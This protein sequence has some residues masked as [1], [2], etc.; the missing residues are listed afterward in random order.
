MSKKRSKSNSSK[1]RK[2]K[3][4]SS[5]KKVNKKREKGNSGKDKKKKSQKEKKEEEEES[6][7]ESS[8]LKRWVIAVVMF[9]LALIVAFAFFDKAG[10][11][12]EIIL[13]AFEFLIGQAGFSIPF[14]LVLG[15]ILLVRPCKKRVYA[16]IFGGLLLFIVAISGIFETN[17]G[18]KAGG[19]IGYIFSWPF[20]KYFTVLVSNIVFSACM[21]IAVLILWE[22][23]PQKGKIK[24]PPIDF[25]K[26]KE[27]INRGKEEEQE[28]ADI[29]ESSQPEVETPELGVKENQESLEGKKKDRKEKKAKEKESKKELGKQLGLEEEKSSRSSASRQDYNPPPLNLLGLPKGR[30]SGG[31][32]QKDAEIIKETLANFGISVEMGE[33]SVG[34]TV[35]RYTLKPDK[36]I[37]LS[38]IT[39]LN[40]DLALALA[41]HPI[42]IEAPIPGRA[43]VGVEV[44][45][46][47]KTEVRLRELLASSEFQKASTPLTFSLGKDVSG[48][49]VLTDLG[50]MPHLLVAG[51]TG[52]GKT[53]FLQGLITSFL[54]RN[55]PQKLRLMLIDPKRVEFSIYKSIPHV[56]GPVI[57][58][59]SKAVNVLNWLVEE[60]ERRFDLMSEVRA[61]D[62]SAFNATISKHQK[63]KEKY[64]IMPRI[65]L[66]IDE[67]ADLMAAK[68]K[69][70]ES[71]IVR[72]SQLSRAVGIHLVVATQRP[73]VDV[74]TGLIKANLIARVA[75]QVAGQA[76][77]RTVLDMGGAENLLGNGDMLFLPSDSAKPKRVQGT[78]VAQENVK[79]VVEYVEQ[80][81]EFEDSGEIEKRLS[82]GLEESEEGEKNENLEE[83]N[84]PLYNKAKEMVVEY[85]KASASFIQ[86]RLGVGYAR[87][88]RIMDM[89]EQEGVVSP[90]EGS[91]PRQILIDKLDSEE[92]EE[93][94]SGSSEES[95]EESEDEDKGEDSDWE[96]T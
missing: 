50:K 95:Q 39:A 96:K 47:G 26:I 10:K 38:R 16:Y 22:V 83:F 77:S 82:E 29:E 62:I 23:V 63:L 32:T 67:L 45:N 69:E 71:S 55:S 27:K 18:E 57:H 58:Q 64:G 85:R 49:L 42:R 30:P 40:N 37:K 31:N 59:P 81:N 25:S 52:S 35:T 74:I 80:H 3:K 73:S 7:I 72:L 17:L 24:W 90:Q 34:P 14:L 91:K 68:G 86:R 2:R 33:I 70:V 19:I 12:G 4:S 66:V 11:G 53:V 46:K 9:A 89:L 6:V 94:S 41:R 1:N 61:K 20:L 15:G 5:Q 75:F 44:P 84:E 13:E 51:S 65:V 43:L 56:L 88:A 36:G 87:A 93:E 60:M 92:S 76:D 48:G 8:R 21:V 54:Y 79:K 28:E 78:F